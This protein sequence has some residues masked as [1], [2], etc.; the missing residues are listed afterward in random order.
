MSGCATPAFET[1]EAASRQDAI[2]DL[3]KLS[4]YCLNPEH[5]RGRHKALVFKSALGLT[6]ADAELL[7]AELLKAAREK[8]AVFYGKDDFGDRFWIVL[9]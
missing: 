1:D 4:G 3:K 2:V 7:K 5:L 9:K 6:T 8:D